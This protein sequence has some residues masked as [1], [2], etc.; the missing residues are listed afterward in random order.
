LAKPAPTNHVPPGLTKYINAS[1]ALKVVAASENPLAP[2]AHY[3][4]SN[5]GG[6][7]QNL[8]RSLQRSFGV[9]CSRNTRPVKLLSRVFWAR[10]KK[11]SNML[12]LL[13]YITRRRVLYAMRRALLISQMKNQR[14]K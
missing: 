4:L 2:R 1:F 12:L 5:G 6:C 14:G 8:F 11:L 13:L 7:S 10:Q 3:T 9:G